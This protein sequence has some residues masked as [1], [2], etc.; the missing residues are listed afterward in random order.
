MRRTTMMQAQWKADAQ[1]GEALTFERCKG[2]YFSD[3]GEFGLK[4]VGKT[5]QK[6]RTGKNLFDYTKASLREDY[7]DGL[8]TI[9]DNGVSYFGDYYF[10]TP[11][12]LAK[13][14]AYTASYSGNNVGTYSIGFGGNNVAIVN[15][16]SGESFVWDFDE[17][18]AYLYLY[19][20]TPT[21]VGE[22]LFLNIQFEEGYTATEYE[23]YCGG[24]PSPNPDYPQP[25]RCVRAG[26]RIRCRGKNLLRYSRIPTSKNYSNQAA[27]SVVAGAYA[28]SAM[29]TD[30]TN[31]GINGGNTYAVIFRNEN[32]EIVKSLGASGGVITAEQAE[33]IKIVSVYFLKDGYSGTAEEILVQLEVGSAATPYE[34]YVEPTEITTPC[35]L[36][37][38]DVWYP[39]SGR[40][41]RNRGFRQLT[42]YEAWEGDTE[43][44]Y[45]TDNCNMGVHYCSH[46]QN[47]SPAPYYASV[48]GVQRFYV[49]G[50]YPTL[51]DFTEFLREQYSNGTPVVIE[52]PLRIPSVE[53][54]T[55]HPHRGRHGH[56]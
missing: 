51:A 16:R 18:E 43:K 42:G 2:G 41:E 46:F 38:G 23:P 4:A 48:G 11:I 31:D 47:H 15:K 26:T 21:V 25:I 56:C 1:S 14:K 24:I 54:Y 27:V 13:G 37:E 55:P 34:P 17:T 20:D 30:G 44:Y 33:K 6:T 9:V 45:I 36:Y 40:V 3:R 32:G 29:N 12:T 49:S 39:A 50:L 35:D 10:Q 8:I 7:S 5:E 19:K 22:A 53:Q 28:V 52:Y